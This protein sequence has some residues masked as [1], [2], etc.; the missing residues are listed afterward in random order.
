MKKR[1]ELLLLLLSS[2]FSFSSSVDYLFVLITFIE[3]I[4]KIIRVFFVGSEQTIFGKL[5]R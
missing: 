4:A 1:N 3:N 5:K 2:F